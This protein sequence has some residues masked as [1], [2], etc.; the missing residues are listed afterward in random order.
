MTG[1]LES[2]FAY[3]HAVVAMTYTN[4]NLSVPAQPFS[5]PWTQCSAYL[6]IS[7]IHRQTASMHSICM[8]WNGLQT[9]HPHL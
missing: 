1:V 5:T 6:K 9:M 4:L 2:G 7:H 8:S 3:I